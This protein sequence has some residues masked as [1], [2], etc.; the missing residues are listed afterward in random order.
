MAVGVVWFCFRGRF[1]VA[2]LL[3]LWGIG[4]FGGFA[5]GVVWWVVLAVSCGFPDGSTQLL[6]AMIVHDILVTDLGV[7]ISLSTCR[8]AGALA[9]TERIAPQTIAHVCS[10]VD[11]DRVARAEL[12]AWCCRLESWG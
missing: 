5:F 7:D 2:V 6:P 12:A 11:P 8:F 9:Q 3:G 10:S 4:G 1:G